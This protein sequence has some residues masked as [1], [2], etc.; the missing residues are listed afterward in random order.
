MATNQ[1]RSE[2]SRIEAVEIANGDVVIYDVDD[3]GAWIQSDG[4]VDADEMA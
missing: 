4:T 1:S 3:T 2:S